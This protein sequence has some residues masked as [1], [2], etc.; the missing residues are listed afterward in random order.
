L[1]FI[2]DGQAMRALVMLKWVPGVPEKEARRELAKIANIIR[3]RPGDRGAKLP[4]GDRLNEFIR[5]MAHWIQEAN[6]LSVKG[7]PKALAAR[8]HETRPDL[9]DEQQEKICAALIQ[10]ARFD[11]GSVRKPKSWALKT[12]AVVYGTEP[13]AIEKRISRDLRSG[14]RKR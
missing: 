9:N 7:N 3:R 4:H 8:I 13:K 1:E 2:T 12:F 6:L 11:R 10:G 5:R 14:R